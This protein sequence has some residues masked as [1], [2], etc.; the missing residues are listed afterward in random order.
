M[1]KCSQLTGI[2]SNLSLTTVNESDSVSCVLMLIEAGRFFCLLF[3]ALKGHA[4]MSSKMAIDRTATFGHKFI[5]RS[6]ETNEH[7]VE[8]LKPLGKFTE[9]Q[10]YVAWQ[11]KCPFCNSEFVIASNSL[12]KQKTC[13]S[14][15]CRIRGRTR[16]PAQKYWSVIKRSSHEVTWNTEKEFVDFCASI[17]LRQTPSDRRA[18]ICEDPSRPVGPDNYRI[19]KTAG[20]WMKSQTVKYKENWITK[21]AAA[22]L[23][24]IT[25]QRAHQLS[26][27]AL[28]SRLESLNE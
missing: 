3:L 24:G 12:A 26:I 1:N 25:R 10:K 23:L 22:K 21:S 28:T 2:L 9:G 14:D 27:E 16:T 8:I 6:G 7:G 15:S 20:T 5:D 13:G 11:C 17:G 18:L 19:T 4:V